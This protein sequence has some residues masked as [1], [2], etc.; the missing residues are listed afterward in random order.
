MIIYHGST[1]RVDKPE[2]RTSENFLD[3]G[4]GFYATTSFEQAQRWARIKMRRENKNIGYVS[5]YKFDFEKAETET[6]IHR[7]NEADIEWLKFVVSNRSGQNS[8]EKVDMN[9]GPVAD[10]NVYRSI[11]LFETGILDAEETVKR[12]K[13]EVLQDQW[14]FH[15]EKMLSYLTFIESKQIRQ[16]EQL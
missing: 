2:I 7:Y 1:A 8:S 16:E 6:V 12:L 13:T 11:R 14:T 10:D 3:F 4:A 9:I 5:V 15:T